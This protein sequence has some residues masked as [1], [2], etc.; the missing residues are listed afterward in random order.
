[1][2]LPWV[3]MDTNLPSHDKILALL[4]D[5]STK[6]WQ[7]AACYHFGIEWSGGHGTDG[8]VPEYALTA[9]HAT[10]F[11]ARL[12]VKYGLWDEGIGG[13]LIRNFADR[14]QTRA[15]GEEVRKA[16]HLG[17]LKGNCIRHHGDDCGCW[18]EAS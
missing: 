17:A 2:A 15:T 4:S 16:Q 5:P 10:P 12:L 7:A 9:I 8:R 18:R 3:R 11:V 6:K 1:M 13:W 14:Q